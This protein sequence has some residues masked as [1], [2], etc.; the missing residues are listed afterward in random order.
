MAL[1]GKPWDNAEVGVL[2]GTRS[3]R[4]QIRAEREPRPLIVA[5]GLATGWWPKRGNA[6]VGVMPS[7][8]ACGARPSAGWAIQGKMAL[9]GKPWDNAEVGVLGGTRS[10]RPQ[11]RAEREP[12]PLI[13]ADG[14]ATG[15]WPKRGN[16]GVG[17][18]P[19]L[20]ACG[21]RPSEERPNATSVAPRGKC[22]R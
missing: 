19:S 9:R 5:D 8:R 1:R 12:R 15:W 22:R 3:P 20:R 14:L 21:A 2:G 10:P 13:V 7:L 17:V 16:A 4:P 6:G 18:M 11:I